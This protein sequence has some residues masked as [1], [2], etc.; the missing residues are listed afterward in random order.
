MHWGI[1][2][3]ASMWRYVYRLPQDLLLCYID[4]LLCEAIKNESAEVCH[5]ACSMLF[6]QPMFKYSITSDSEGSDVIDLST[7]DTF[8]GPR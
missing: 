3:L 6:P 4:Y 1:V 7:K 5:N 8:Q 2:I